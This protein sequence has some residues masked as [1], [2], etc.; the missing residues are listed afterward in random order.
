MKK[1]AAL[2]LFLFC[3]A[4]SVL[5]AIVLAIA[6]LFEE[7]GALFR[8]VSWRMDVIANT[9]DAWGEGGDAG[10]NLPATA[11]WK[12]RSYLVLAAGICVFA[13]LPVWGARAPAAPLVLLS[14]LALAGLLAF[15]WRSKWLRVVTVGLGALWALNETGTLL[16]KIEYNTPF[17]AYFA[18][19]VLAT[20]PTEATGM[21]FEHIGYLPVF[22]ALFAAAI[23]LARRMAAGLSVRFLGPAAAVFVL[24]TGGMFAKYLIGGKTVP[25]AATK[26]LIKTPFYNAG[27]LLA[28]HDE[29]DRLQRQNLPEVSHDIRNCE[30]GIETYVLVIGESARRG[31]LSLY[32]YTR[33]TTPCEN[34]EKD[35]MLLFANAISPAPGTLSSVP[36][37]LCPPE[38]GGAWPANVRDNIISLA[39]QAGF[40]TFWLSN[41]EAFSPFDTGT[42]AIAKCAGTTSWAYARHDGI[43]LPKLESALN[44]PGR[45]LIVMHLHGSHE[46]FG[47]NFPADC[48]RFGGRTANED[49]YDNSIYYTDTL[50]GKIFDRL[51]TEKASVFYYS[52]H[53]LIRKKNLWYW[54][55]RHGGQ[56][57]EAY[58]IPMWIWF[59]P[60]VPAPPRLG[61]VEAFWCAGENYNLCKDWLG[62]E[63]TGGTGA[64]VS[65]LS[66][67]WSPAGEIWVWPTESRRVLFADLEHEP[68][69]DK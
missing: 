14:G 35:R 34:A 19:S 15:C 32:G 9:A 33:D 4:V 40:Q 60:A 51:K 30:T 66:P 64:G 27:T 46:P 26:V 39:S 37:T 6:W 61:V 63:T 2:F 49:N 21:M 67:G 28:A 52:D 17:A 68:A 16:S 3:A 43:L 55:Y 59:S 69:L 38:P 50:I 36:R 54:K 41:Q 47:N 18:E 31:N 1:I 24:F 8:R 25:L 20:N 5:S 23:L 45:K 7:T 13:L 12:T 56:Y 22:F 11:F 62:M 44:V 48:A 58:E 42:T 57:K 53:A 29:M 65:P 10:R